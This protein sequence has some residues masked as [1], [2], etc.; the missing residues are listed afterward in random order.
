[1]KF[2]L[3]GKWYPFGMK[4]LSRWNSLISGLWL[5]QL[6]GIARFRCSICFAKRQCQYIDVSTAVDMTFWQVKDDI[7]LIKSSRLRYATLSG[8]HLDRS[9]DVARDD[10]GAVN[11]PSTAL[12]N[13][14][15][16]GQDDF[17]YASQRGSAYIEMS[18][19]RST[20]HSGRSYLRPKSLY[21]RW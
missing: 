18:P 19:L 8:W 13:D 11:S 12:E 6:Y 3:N 14:D 1:M 16:Y 9:L 15:L 5:W 2:A 20:W 21:Y 4:S 10:S 17:P 7:I